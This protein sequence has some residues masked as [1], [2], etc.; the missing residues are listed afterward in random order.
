MMN[1][2]SPIGGGHSALTDHE[3]RQLRQ[4]CRDLEEVF[5]RYVVREMGLLA[6]Q[7][8]GGPG[9]AGSAQYGAL[10]EEALASALTDAGGIG[11]AETLY[12]Q[13]KEAAAGAAREVSQGALELPHDSPMTRHDRHRPAPV[14]GET[15]R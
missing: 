13:L 7:T 3:D 4:A 10:A 9:T 11:I 2:T 14:E 5:M 15:A 8:G 1:E 12:T 6:K